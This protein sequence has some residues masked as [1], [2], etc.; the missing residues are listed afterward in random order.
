MKEHNTDERN[1]SINNYP[2]NM[3]KRFFSKRRIIEFC[4]RILKEG[5]EFRSKKFGLPKMCRNIEGVILTRLSP[6]LTWH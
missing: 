4:S 1:F 3:T 5:R 6:L 2:F